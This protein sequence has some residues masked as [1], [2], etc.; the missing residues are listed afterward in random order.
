MKLNPVSSSQIHA[1]G[2]DHETNT[3]HVQFRGKDGPGHTYAYSGVSESDHQALIGAESIGSH[4][5]QHIKNAKNDEG[6]PRFPFTKLP[7]DYD[8]EQAK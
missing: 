7:A 2:H 8:A 5:G 3:L 1:I 4:F 6:Q